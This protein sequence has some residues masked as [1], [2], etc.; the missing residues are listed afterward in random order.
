MPCSRML[1]LGVS[2]DAGIKLVIL[3]FCTCDFYLSY[4]AS[5]AGSGLKEWQEDKCTTP[6][7]SLQS[8]KVMMLRDML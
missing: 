1:G 8:L 6:T 2:A 5:R 3:H 4:L 7:F